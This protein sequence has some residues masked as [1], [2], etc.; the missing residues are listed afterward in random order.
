M[1]AENLCVEHYYLNPEW[2]LETKKLFLLYDDV[3]THEIRIYFIRDQNY[4]KVL[5]SILF[6]F[7][8]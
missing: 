3:L 5:N 4:S 7:R 1:L 2:H 6:Y 8:N